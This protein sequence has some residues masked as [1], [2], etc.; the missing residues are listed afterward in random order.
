MIFIVKA[1][2]VSSG[3]V[4]TLGACVGCMIGTCFG[5]QPN[6]PHDPWM[7]LKC[8]L[9]FGAAGVFYPITTLILYTYKPKK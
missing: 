3:V 8:T 1:F 2:L 6:M 7:P 5:G 9:V 4:G